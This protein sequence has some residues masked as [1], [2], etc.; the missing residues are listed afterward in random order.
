[1]GRKRVPCHTA[2]LAGD[3]YVRVELAEESE[4]NGIVVKG[5]EGYTLAIICEEYSAKNGVRT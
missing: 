5:D 3:G 1:M 4:Q 2:I